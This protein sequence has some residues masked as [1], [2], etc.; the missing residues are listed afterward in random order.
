MDENI[1]ISD[2][3]NLCSV[4]RAT[5]WRWIK[6]GK[7]QASKTA[8]GHHRVSERDFLD[9]M[10]DQQMHKQFRGD[11]S[12][13]ILVVDD[14]ELIRK[15]FK[16]LLNSADIALEFAKDGFDAGIKT[17]TFKPQ[18]II[19]DLFM[20][21]MDGFSVCRQI[22]TTRETSSI[23]VLA[24]SGY[25]SPKNREKIFSSG[26]DAFLAKPIDSQIMLKKI[27]TLLNARLLNAS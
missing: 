26:A 27:D 23:K 1:T 15:Y 16:K 10:N 18:L 11:I 20:P 14:D 22:K 5:I 25:D 12:K 8:G 21:K 24:I 2:A 19:L 17:I 6:S 13:K 3:S 9:F 4:S 7:L